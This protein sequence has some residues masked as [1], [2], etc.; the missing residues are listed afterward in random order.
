VTVFSAKPRPWWVV[1]VGGS[2]PLMRYEIEGAAELSCRERNDRAKNYDI[3]CRYEVVF[4]DEE[5][6]E[7]SLCKTTTSQDGP[8]VMLL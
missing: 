2:D 4:R 5:N 1:Q 7:R 8:S 6:C 3:E